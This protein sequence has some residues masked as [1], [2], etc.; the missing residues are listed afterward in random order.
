MRSLS[1]S[2]TRFKNICQVTSPPCQWTRRRR[3]WWEIQECGRNFVLKAI[4]GRL[5]HRLHYSRTWESS[6]LRGLRHGENS[7]WVSVGTDH[8]TAAFAVETIRRWWYSMGHKAY[9]NAKRLLITADS[10]GS[11]GS[12]VR[13]WKLELQ[14]S[15]TTRRWK[16]SRHFRQEPANGTRLSIDCFHS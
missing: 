5:V 6:S 3:S 10:G 12:R 9:P 15:Q 2:V 16:F 4:R 11:N 8:D 1:I 14:S 13:L 7:G